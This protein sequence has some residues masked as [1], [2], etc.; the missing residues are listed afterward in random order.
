MDNDIDG[1]QDRLNNKLKADY[2]SQLKEFKIGLRPFEEFYFDESSRGDPGSRGNA[3][4][5]SPSPQFGAQTLKKS[6]KNSVINMNNY[7]SQNHL[8]FGEAQG[9]V[10]ENSE[11][12]ER[13]FQ[14]I[15]DTFEQAKP[16]FGNKPDPLK[17]QNLPSRLPSIP[18]AK[19]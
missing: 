13:Q 5:N 9:V 15:Q 6:L 14:S 16:S 11:E 3:R 10:H 2:I 19:K 8:D 17:Q 18:E 12:L 4:S 1:I 7:V